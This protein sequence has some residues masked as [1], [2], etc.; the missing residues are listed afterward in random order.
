[1]LT[2]SGRRPS[3]PTLDGI[4]QL[5]QRLASVP[6]RLR[7]GRLPAWWP[8]ALA[9]A[10]S[11]P[12]TLYWWQLIVG[13]SVAF[14][15]RIFVEAGTR[16]WQGSPDLYEVTDVYS[17]RH[18]PLMAFAMPAIAWIGTLGIRLVTL[19]AA[20]AM[21]TWPMRLLALASWPFAVD[22]QHGTFIM[23]MVCA[24]A[25]ALRGHRWASIAYLVLTLLSPRPL[26]LPVAAWLVWRQPDIRVRAVLLVVAN[27]IG[28]L[29]TGYADEWIT[30]LLGTGTDM[31][32]APFNLAPSRLIGSWWVPIGI[33]LAAWLTL[34]GRVGLAALAANP[35]VLPHYLLFALLELLPGRR[36]TG[37]AE[38][39]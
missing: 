18:S 3:L 39:R 16:F 24:A 9:L 33:V 12:L 21:P 32:E 1:M 10:V 20:L 25:W 27:A 17:F 38:A 29:A 13:G 8:L 36:S 28:V 34:R 6:A 7:G 30:M 15:W 4:A 2:G 35:Y 11:A 19:G 22:V 14:D 31:V 5:T 26:M 37:T 23:V